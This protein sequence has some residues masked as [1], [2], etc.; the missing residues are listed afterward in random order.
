[1]PM[2]QGEPLLLVKEVDAG[3]PTLGGVA[4][5]TGDST[6]RPACKI[7]GVQCGRNMVEGMGLLLCVTVIWVAASELV[8]VRA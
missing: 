2:S 6:S 1:M 5:T 8:Q 3:L 4:V 7:L